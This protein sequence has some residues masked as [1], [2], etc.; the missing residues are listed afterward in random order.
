MKKILT[1]ASS[2]MVFLFVG[3][4]AVA[5]DDAEEPS[6]V[7]V[8]IWACSYNDGKG[9]ADLD[10][11]ID[12]WNDWMD[13]EGQTNY[14]A[15][16]LEPAFFGERNLD[17]G[18]LG[19]Y[20]DGNAM[21]AGTDHWISKGGDV[22]D[23]FGEVISCGQ[24]AM[25]ATMEMR[26]PGEPE[27]GDDDF[28]LAFSNCSI[29]EGKTFEDVQAAQELWN[30]YGAEHGFTGGAWV[31]WPI[32]GENVEADYDFKFLGS[33]DDFTALGANYQLMAD[34][35]WRKNNEIWDGLLD[36]DSTRIYASTAIRRMADDE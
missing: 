14:Y 11:V 28:V 25:F 18:W 1:A 12:E 5:Q 26:D 7:P 9:R 32:W 8:E 33:A 30:A 21:G 31:M 4:S 20:P 23:S 27:E 19:V 16:I 17:I 35:H 29:N 13:E 36:C 10:A 22:N 2:A 24:H 3:S 6:I 34:G 15:A